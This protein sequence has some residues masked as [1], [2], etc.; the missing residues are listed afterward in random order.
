MGHS[1]A[2][3]H[4]E[5]WVRCWIAPRIKTAFRRVFEILTAVSTSGRERRR[6]YRIAVKFS[7]L[8]HRRIFGEVPIVRRRFTPTRRSF[9]PFLAA[10]V[11]TAAPNG[12]GD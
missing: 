7:G 5:K 8:F 3:S 11:H 4:S 10:G 6:S 1:A 2:Q 9:S 12:E